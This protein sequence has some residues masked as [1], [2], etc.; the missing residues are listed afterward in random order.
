MPLGKRFI[1][2]PW[3]F[4]VFLDTVTRYLDILTGVPIYM[5]KNACMNTCSLPH[6]NTDDLIPLIIFTHLCTH[7]FIPTFIPT[8]KPTLSHITHLYTHTLIHS[9]AH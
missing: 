3:L 7:K 5:Y 6:T 1:R 2:K 9:H 4:V 8:P